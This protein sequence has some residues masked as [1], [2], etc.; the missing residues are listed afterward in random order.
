MPSGGHVVQ[1]HAGW[2]TR[3]N[4]DWGW[5]YALRTGEQS[6]TGKGSRMKARYFG[7]LT[8]RLLSRPFADLLGGH[9]TC[10]WFVSL[11]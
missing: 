1:T 2:L 3:V 8:V 11:R 7:T 4:A 9:R 10:G 5:G 6:A